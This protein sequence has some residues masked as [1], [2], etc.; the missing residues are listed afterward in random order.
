MQFSLDTPRQGVA[1]TAATASEITLRHLESGRERTLRHSFILTSDGEITAWGATIPPWRAADWL[2][3]ADIA[4]PTL[5]VG[6]GARLIFPAGELLAPLYQQQIGIEFMNNSAACRTW[7][8]LV[9]EG[10]VAT[11]AIMLPESG[12]R[13]LE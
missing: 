1:I 6:T 8:I 13:L 11:L 3:L 9:S 12:D 10:R 5:L 2:L 7:N 4:A